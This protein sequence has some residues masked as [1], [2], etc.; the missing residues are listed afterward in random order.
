M[1]TPHHKI[2]GYT[3]AMPS[4]ISQVYPTT[5][6]DPVAVEDM[7][8]PASTS[9]I[10]GDFI[11]DGSSITV[12]HRSLRVNQ[13][14]RQAATDAGVPLIDVERYW[15]KAVATYGES[16]LFDTGETVHPN[17]LGHQQSYWLAIDEFVESLGR[18]T[19]Q[20]GQEPRLNGL[21]GINNS[22]PTAVLDVDIPYPDMTSP[23]LQVRARV[24]VADANSIKGA[25]IVWK[26]D[27]A[28]GDL[29]GYGVSVVDSSSIECYRHHA[30]VSSGTVYSKQTTHS[31][32]VTLYK[33]SFGGQV[34]A[35][36]TVTVIDVPDNSYGT[37]RINGYH[38]GVGR[39]RTSI[40]WISNSGA[41]SFGTA[42]SAGAAT[43]T[44]PTASGLN[45][46]VTCFASGTSLNY[47]L[48]SNSGI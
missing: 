37:I 30:F 9:S 42:D 35:G 33:E 47:E 4:G 23:P 27:P 6:A 44:G 29:V 38:N 24:G 48:V 32:Y 15:F 34:N 1:T 14:M 41:I 12:S 8:P 3:F 18:Q 28:N 19:A 31:C 21:V 26:V 5:V 11:G 43:F 45:I 39:R 40:E 2:S 16:A 46:Q 25:G 22:L 7:I 10:T 13:A 36:G 20:E 17:L